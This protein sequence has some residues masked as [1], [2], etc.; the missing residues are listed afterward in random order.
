MTL[1]FLTAG[2]SHG[3]ELVA[4]VEGLPAGLY[5]SRQAIDRE[6]SRRQQGYGRGRRMQIE[7][8]HIRWI[9]GVR[10]GFTLGSP[11]ALAI[12]NRDWPH[13]QEVMSADPVPSEAAGDRR[14]LSRALHRPRPG[15]A[16][17]SGGLKYGHRDLRNVLERASAR[18]TAAR[19]AV[20][21][22][23]RQ[24]L[25][26]FGVRLASLV[27]ELGQVAA[28]PATYLETSSEAPRPIADWQEV[29]EAS[30]VRCPD[31]EAAAAMM[32]A[33]DRAREEGDTLGGIF[34]VVVEGL[35]PGLGSYASWDRRLDGRLAASL[36]SIPAIK[37]V[38]IGLG[39]TA[40]RRPGSEVHDA[41]TYDP[42]E[43][44]F[45]RPTNR[46]G[47]LEG[48]VT[49]GE[50]LWLRAAM[51]P[52]AT[53]VRPLAS[54][55]IETGEPVMAA[56]ERS[57]VCAVPAAAVVGEAQVA[58]EL[59]CAWMEKFG[60]DSLAEVERNVAGYL[61]AVRNYVGKYHG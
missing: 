45:R 26:H 3:P 52:I 31:P 18:E 51:K 24:L 23:A 40:A 19:V 5:L 59:A 12:A 33:I 22:V 7:H 58:W 9:G 56:V 21:A 44:K 32:T 34:L 48:G 16:D 46:A 30:P 61:E 35:P 8:D 2:E 60:G 1:R 15:H 36:M 50:T 39:F 11:V 42:G 54:V 53:L 49:N 14:A 38:E 10:H 20:G 17:L 28:D 57:D 6:L 43:R 27:V 47:G 4:I 41:I 55:D 13:W 37:G 29:V 25:A